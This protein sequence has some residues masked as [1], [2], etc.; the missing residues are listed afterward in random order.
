VKN[1]HNQIGHLLKKSAL[2]ASPFRGTNPTSFFYS[3]PTCLIFILDVHETS[4]IAQI[5][6]D[7]LFYCS[8]L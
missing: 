6:P 5:L 4:G 2:F 7:F 8:L 3:H 1:L